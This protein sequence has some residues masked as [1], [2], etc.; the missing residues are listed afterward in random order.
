MRQSSPIRG[1]NMNVLPSAKSATVLPGAPAGPGLSP[2]WSCFH[3]LPL[4]SPVEVWRQESWPCKS[5]GP[6]SL[7]LK[8]PCSAQLAHEG[9]LSVHTGESTIW[10]TCCE[11][12][13]FSSV[14]L[15]PEFFGSKNDYLHFLRGPLGKSLPT[16]RLVVG[17][18]RKGHSYL[19]FQ[20]KL[21]V[22]KGDKA[23][24]TLNALQSGIYIMFPLGS[25]CSWPLDLLFSASDRAELLW[26]ALSQHVYPVCHPQCPVHCPAW[27]QICGSSLSKQQP[28]WVLVSYV[29]ASVCEAHKDNKRISAFSL[30]FR[31]FSHFSGGRRTQIIINRLKEN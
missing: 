22:S 20:V 3:V 29:T 13:Y 8:I 27:K 15:E 6:G 14:L 19:R 5:H 30:Y 2:L 18:T 31:L 25:L 21:A 4:D 9:T 23:I 28:F 12:P 7:V 1:I 11:R 17:G 10:K 16:S 26:P 24:P